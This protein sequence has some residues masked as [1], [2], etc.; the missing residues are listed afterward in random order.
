MAEPQSRVTVVEQVYHQIL[1]EQP[2]LVESR[3][4]RGLQSDE[5]AYERRLKVDEGGMPLDCGWLTEASQLLII[6][7]EGRN[8]QVIPTDEERKELAKKVLEIFFGDRP[9]NCWLVPPGESM[10][11]CSNTLHALKI[12]SQSGTIRFTLHVIPK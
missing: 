3:F 2:H 4:S 1:N 12:R 5:Q 6:N 11:A 10:R 8:L 7:E 9:D